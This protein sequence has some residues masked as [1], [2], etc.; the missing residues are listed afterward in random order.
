MSDPFMA[1]IRIFASSFA[2]RDWYVCNGQLV[3]I[4][5]NTAL[6]SLI[7]NI[8]GGDGRTT[9]GLPNLQGRVPMGQGTGPGLPTNIL[10]QLSGTPVVALDQTTMPAHSHTLTG[11]GEQGNINAPA[12]AY[13]ASDAGGASGTR[14]RYVKASATPDTTMNGN[15]FSTTGAG[16]A[17]ENRQPYLTL[18]FCISGQGMYPPRN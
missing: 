3:N 11:Q 13:M 14:I 2:P 6:F 5:Q 12:G 1:E 8:Y 16:N 4:S 17:H 9:M 18:L 15:A 7:G 10:G